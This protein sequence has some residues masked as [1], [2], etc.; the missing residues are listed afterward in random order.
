[1]MIIVMLILSYLIGAFPSGLIIGK[2]FFK[3]DIRQYGSGNTGA[4]NSFRVLGRPA[5]FIVTFLDIFKGFITVFFPLWFPVHADGVIST[6]FTNGLIVGL[7][8]ILGHVYPIYLNFNGGKAVATSAGVVLGVNPILLLILAIIFF[9]VLKIFKY[10]SLSSI[11]AAISCV[12][13]SIIIH[14]YIL[15]AVS[16][17][18]SIILIIRHKSNIVRI[19]KG[20]EP[21]IKWM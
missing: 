1:M 3:K 19:F 20:E 15:L 4:T 13:G 7:F 8:A 2:L 18:V 9:S 14:D 16:G 17:I 10:V 12:I 21:K 6:F 11:I 5:G